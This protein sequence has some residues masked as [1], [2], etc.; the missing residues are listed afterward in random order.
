MRLIDVKNLKTTITRKV[1]AFLERPYSEFIAF[2]LVAI[3][4]YFLTYIPDMLAGR[5]FI[6]VLNLQNQMYIYHSTLTARN[7]WES[8]WYSW[9]LLFD[10]VKPTTYVPYWLEVAYLP[11]G[12]ISTI[13]LLGNPAV[14]WVGFAAIIG[15]TVF[16]VPKILKKRF[17]FSLKQNLPAVF[18]LVIFFFQWLAYIFVSR[19]TYV[20]SFYSNVPFICLGSAFFIDRYWSSKYAK[21]L[22]VV[23]FALVVGLF[24]LFYPVISGVPTSPS[25]INSL[26]WF[27]SWYF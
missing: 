17:R 24:V 19:G 1:Y 8:P 9:P 2:I 3:G 25:T 18:I 20:Y 10:P 4:I 7:G 12:T 11:N 15:L 14:W 6:D 22:A 26:K 23:F 27:H 13:T 5:S 16:T 21:V